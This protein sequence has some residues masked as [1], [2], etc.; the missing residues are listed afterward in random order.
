[1]GLDTVGDATRAESS[2]EQ[3]G[4]EG[5][6]AGSQL[7]EERRPGQASQGVWEGSHNLA[8]LNL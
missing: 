2:W 8:G 5:G 1:V 3:V 7:E 6:R 4:W